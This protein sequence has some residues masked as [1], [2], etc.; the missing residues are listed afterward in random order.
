MRHGSVWGEQE[1]RVLLVEDEPK[2]AAVISDILKFNGFTADSVGTLEDASESVAVVTYDAILLDRKLP[3]GD[4]L[5]WLRHRR[6]SGWPIPALIL[7]A[8]MDSV[9]DRIEGLNA[10]ADDY[11]LKPVNMDELIARLRA[12]L[13]RPTTALGP[14]MR[15]G[16]VE[17]DPAGRQVWVN[18]VSVKVPRRE[19]CL[20]EVLM[21]RFGRVVPKSALE[22]SLFSYDN[23][24]SSNALEVGIYRLRSHLSKSGAAVSIRT[25]RGIGYILELAHPTASDTKQASG[26]SSEVSR[27]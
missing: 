8:E 18:G 1:M 27:A 24:V 16:N 25:D 21:R 12:V 23:D 2:V 19:I 7:T 22:E 17:F 15:A 6:R 10:G 14:V 9:D 13:R 20:L 3:D 4:G 5:H 26:K 11:I